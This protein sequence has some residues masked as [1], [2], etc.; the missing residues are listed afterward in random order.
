[1]KI[2]SIFFLLFIGFGFNIIKAQK[3][4]DEFISH[5]VKKNET[6]YGITRNYNITQEELLEFNPILR[7]VK[8]KKR[9]MLRIP[10]FKYLANPKNL[11]KT[12][13]VNILKNTET[14]VVKPKETKWRIAYN[15]EIT[16]SELERLNPEIKG[17]LNAGQKIQ[18][19]ILDSIKVGQ[20]W[21]SNF[22]YYEV[23]DKEGYYR[24]EKKIGVKKMV[25]DSL[26]PQLLDLGLQS[27]M[28][29][30]VPYESKGTL[31]IQNDLLVEK[32][33]LIDSFRKIDKVKLLVLLPFK[34]NEIQFDSIDNTQR[35]L[36]SRNLH[37]IS[38]DFYSGLLFA[39]DT[40]SKRGISIKIDTYDTENNIYRINEIIDEYD[41]S[42]LDAIIGPLIPTN[43]DFIS[44]KKRLGSIPKFS[45]LST[46]SINLNSSVYQSITSKEFLR[47]K[48]FDFLD[49]EINREDNI[50]L[51]VDSI[52]R[53]IE[54]KLLK[55][56]PKSTI[57]RPEKNNYLMPELVDSLLVD[58]LPNRVILESQDFSLISSASSQMS[59]QQSNEREVQL[60]TTYRG[61]VYENQ[62][63]SIKQLGD[64]NFTYTANSIP[65]KLGEY[66]FFQNKF[67]EKFGKPPTRT[68]IRGYDFTIDLILRYTY[69]GDLRKIDELGET[70][71]QENRFN[72]FREEN[73]FL[74]KGF[75]LLQHKG[76]EIVELKK[77]LN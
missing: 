77:K 46:N 54:R 37:T 61:N 59:A 35:L 74:N 12:E 41:F 76:Y 18:V 65:L 22:N 50:V 14:Y 28:I 10:V 24:I 45:P 68:S 47:K 5:K 70:E 57:L 51:I 66:N 13:E 4:P 38:T 69:T 75:Y 52:N 44:S 19:P 8:L 48:M 34:V 30:R 71:Y 33:S 23:K 36:K 2:K 40:L 55:L 67:I 42:N 60:F 21:D 72:Y 27:G 16:I 64:L 15:F 56:F 49:K 9:M 63:L 31:K 7:K 11:T 20:T 39:A 73:S 17:G 25:L 43:F 3:T 1:M 53:Q 62:S 26:N 6:L 29:L 58:S 32:I